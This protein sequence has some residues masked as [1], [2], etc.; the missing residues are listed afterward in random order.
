MS[1]VLCV[2]IWK[3]FRDF[4]CVFHEVFTKDID[5][6]KT[7]NKL[8]KNEMKIYKGCISMELTDDRNGLKITKK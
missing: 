3:A 8:D 2:Y 1:F 4:L 6:Y 7:N 5:N